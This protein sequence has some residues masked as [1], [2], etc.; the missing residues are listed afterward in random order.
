MTDM[1]EKLFDEDGN[2]YS[3]CGTSYSGSGGVTHLV[4]PK[5]KDKVI[6][7]A[8]LG[9]DVLI[10]TTDTVTWP[11]ITYSA[12]HHAS[13]ISQFELDLGVTQ[14]WGIEHPSWPNFPVPEGFRVALTTHEGISTHESGYL[15]TIPFSQEYKKLMAFK[16]VGLQDGYCYAGD[17]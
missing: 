12:S 3:I 10:T 15:R 8:Q 4:Q 9:E 6:D 1:P 5:P 13:Q 17:E 7:M 11:A 2:E 16:V 14:Y